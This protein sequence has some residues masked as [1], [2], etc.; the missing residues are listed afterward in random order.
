M[1]DFINRVTTRR[2][3]GGAVWAALDAGPADHADWRLWV[4]KRVSFYSPKWL[5]DV[6]G[7]VLAYNAAKNMVL[8]DLDF[9]FMS[10]E[11]VPVEFV[12][13]IDASA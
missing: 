13:V 6:S 10:L 7:T 9:E 11:W 4:D 3:I 8:I 2:E 5:A 12:A 1:T